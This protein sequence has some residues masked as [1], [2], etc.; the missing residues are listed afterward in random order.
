M[1]PH[2]SNSF[3]EFRDD[4]LYLN[5]MENKKYEKRRS[6]NRWHV[7]YDLATWYEIVSTE[8]IYLDEN[9]QKMLDELGETYCEN[10]V[11]IY[12]FHKSSSA[13]VK[14]KNLYFPN[15]TSES[16]FNKMLEELN[17]L[18]GKKPIGIIKLW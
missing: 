3:Y 18:N 14:H 11:A 4:K 12:V 13:P 6:R 1:I 7:T 17:G 2:G 5:D 15:E 9:V 8:N 10:N 16:G